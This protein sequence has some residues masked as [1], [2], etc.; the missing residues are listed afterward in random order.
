MPDKL[1]L[2][3]LFRR[4]PILSDLFKHLNKQEKTYLVVF[5]YEFFNEDLMS[6][7]LLFFFWVY[8]K[9]DMPLKLTR[10]LTMCSVLLCLESFNWQIFLVILI[11]NLT[12]K[13][14]VCGISSKC[15][16][17]SNWL[18]EIRWHLCLGLMQLCY[19]VY[20][21]LRKLLETLT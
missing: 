19:R 5:N 1:L 16:C 3:P 4:N 7:S 10:Y 8:H 13:I 11:L 17:L 21:K 12:E 6:D 15:Y 20:G 2:I 9:F 18:V 14:S